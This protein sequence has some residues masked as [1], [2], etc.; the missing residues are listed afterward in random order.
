MRSGLATF[1]GVAHRLETVGTKDGVRYVNDSKATN[2]DAAVTGVEGFEGGVHLIV[3]GYG[4]G[5]EIDA[6][7]IAAKERAVGAYTIGADGDRA[8]DALAAAGVAVTRAGDMEAAVAAATRAA[9]P[10]E[11][12]LLSPAAKSFDQYV[13][14]EARG[15]H[16]R[17]LARAAGAR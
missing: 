5:A 2:T 3:G 9:R 15:D 1:G 13:D 8:A 14:F 6:L 12:V 7:V 16:F 17:A 10:G 4:L 11:T